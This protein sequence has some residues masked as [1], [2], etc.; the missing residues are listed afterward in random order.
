MDS[1]FKVQ[2]KGIQNP[3]RVAVVLLTLVFSAALPAWTSAQVL[4]TQPGE[5]ADDSSLPKSNP[6]DLCTL[7]GVV[8]K[9]STGEPAKK[10]SVML[11]PA[12]GRRQEQYSATTDAAGRFVIASIEPGKYVLSAGGNGYPHDVYGRS[13]SRG[14]GK[15]FTLERASHTKDIVFRLAPGGVI[16]GTIY[17]EEGDPI[18]GANVQAVRVSG[19]SMRGPTGGGQTNDRGEYRI[20]GLESGHY[21]LLANYDNRNGETTDEVYPP[22]YYPGTADS[23][24]ATTVEVHPGNETSAIDLSLTRVHGV[25]VRGRVMN[26]FSS[27]QQGMYVQLVPASTREAHFGFRSFGAPT[28]DERGSFDI[29]G[30]PP[31]SYVLFSYWND[32]KRSFSGRVSLEVSNTDIDGVTLVLSPPLELRGRVRTDPGAQLDFGRLNIWLQ[33]TENQMN[34]VSPAEITSDGSFVI[35]NVFDGHYRVIVAGHPEEYYLRSARLGGAEVLAS[36]FTISHTQAA[37][38]LELDLTL[39]GGSVSGTVVHDGNPVPG[40]LVELVPDPP[41]RDRFEMYSSKMTDD[42]GRFRMLGL[43]A[44]DFKLFAWETPQGDARDPDYIKTYEKSGTTV[45]IQE[46][47]GQNVQ[48]DVI[49]AEEEQ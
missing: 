43:P 33:P 15:V 31:G 13:Q 47:Q 1:G 26:E 18:V 5:S 17:D 38:A 46:K 19:V 16:T 20:F 42:F 21:Y 49:P 28:Q 11:F 48:L 35:H 27:K 7:E 39:N 2:E 9:S 22:T 37:G 45:H 29:R 44:G 34:G 12:G 32:E 4:I 3:T 24:Q 23:S 6:A 14:R 36:G 41:N 40:A 25:H 30:V 10:V 8:L